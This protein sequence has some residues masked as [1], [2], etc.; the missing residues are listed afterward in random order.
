MPDIQVLRGPTSLLEIKSTSRPPIIGFTNTKCH[1]SRPINHLELNRLE[2]S[3]HTK[4]FLYPN[5][6]YENAK[7]LDELPVPNPSETFFV[8]VAI[9]SNKE[10]I[11]LSFNANLG[12][13]RSITD[14][15]NKIFHEAAQTT[16]ERLSDA[17]KTFIH[18]H[19]IKT[20]TS[21]QPNTSTHKTSITKNDSK[22]FGSTTR[23]RQCWTR[24]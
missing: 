7:S 19:T 1:P 18:C 8:T 15:D 14:E 11:T 3:S 17:W 16:S 4:A 22:T 9:H 12:F 21:K 5:S 24:P 13:I 6:Q 2:Q 20:P 10:Y 23:I